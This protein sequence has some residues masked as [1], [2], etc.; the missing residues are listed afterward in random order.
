[1]ALL[2]LSGTAAN[3]T[4]GGKADSDEPKRRGGRP[5]KT[6]STDAEP[7]VPQPEDAVAVP[8]KRGRKTKAELAAQDALALAEQ[9]QVAA[10]PPP[11]AQTRPPAAAHET[12]ASAA[13]FDT[14][15]HAD[16]DED[17]RRRYPLHRRAAITSSRF[18]GHA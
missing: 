16:I 8:K 10:Q 6:T 17:D 7:D 18:A 12:Q 3:S 5:R 2:T 11:R 9:Q 1:M 13:S 4:T 14:D 15:A